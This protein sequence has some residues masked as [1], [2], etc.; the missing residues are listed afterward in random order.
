RA[1]PFEQLATARAGGGMRGSSSQ[2][3][4]MT[5]AFFGAREAKL[6][7]VASRGI[8][9]ERRVPRELRRGGDRTGRFFVTAGESLA[10]LQL[11]ERP[12][13]FQPLAEFFERARPLAKTHSCRKRAYPVVIGRQHVGLQAGDDLQLVLDVAQEQV[14]VGKFVR[15]FRRQVAE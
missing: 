6:A 12:V 1:E 15:A 5:R 10:K 9:I 2:Q 3:L 7:Q 13:R 4:E 11:D 14:R 8:R